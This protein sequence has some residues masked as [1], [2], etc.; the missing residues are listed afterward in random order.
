MDVVGRNLLNKPLPGSFDIISYMMAVV[1]FSA[2][3]GIAN[4]RSH[5]TVD[6]LDKYYPKWAARVRDVFVELLIGGLMALM[7]W[8]LLVYGIEAHKFNRVSPDIYLPLWPILGFCAMMGFVT[9]AV[10]CNNALK[11]FLERKEK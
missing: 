11:I 8:R 10:H 2:A 3:P 1:V 4:E 5:I 9:S 7:S 6:I